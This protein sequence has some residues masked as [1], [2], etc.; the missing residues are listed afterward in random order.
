MLETVLALAAAL[1]AEGRGSNPSDAGG[2]AIVVGIA[3]LVAIAAAAG[4][5]LVAR[6][7][8]RS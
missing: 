6:R 7:R 8:G 1:L 5:W 2:V 4:M 3:A